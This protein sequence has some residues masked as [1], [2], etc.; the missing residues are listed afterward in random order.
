MKPDLTLVGQLLPL[1]REIVFGWYRPATQAN[2]LKQGT[3]FHIGCSSAG[4]LGA[5]AYNVINQAIDSKDEIH[6]W[7]PESKLAA[8]EL[9][10]TLRKLYGQQQN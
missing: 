10:R 8:Q 5:F 3:Y 1:R 6:I 2:G 7:F 9:K 4:L